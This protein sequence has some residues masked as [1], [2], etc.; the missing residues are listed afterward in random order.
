MRN[1][2]TTGAALLAAFAFPVIVHADECAEGS[3]LIDGNYY[4]Q[5]VKSIQYTNFG[6]TGS[7]NMVTD[8]DSTTGSCSS[9]PYQ[10][11]GSLAPL[12]E[13]VC[14]ILFLIP[15]IHQC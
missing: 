2:I 8:M 12:N 6:G 13:E 7:Y 5:A 11:S 10:Y 1:L 15:S 9:T 4:C 14:L 3:V